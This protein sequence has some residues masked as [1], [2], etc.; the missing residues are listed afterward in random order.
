M[1]ILNLVFGFAFRVHCVQV[2]RNAVLCLFPVSVCSYIQ[3]VSFAKS[4]APFFQDILA[5]EQRKD[6][7]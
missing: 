4:A 2:S 5:E 7:Q 6:C 3:T 1:F